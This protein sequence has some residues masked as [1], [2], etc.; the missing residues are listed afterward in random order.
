VK[1]LDFGVAT[2]MEDGP[3]SSKGRLVGTPVYMSPEQMRR[4][5]VDGRTDQFSWGVVAYELLSGATPWR[6]DGDAMTLASE[7][8]TRAAEPLRDRARDV[9]PNVADTV[10]RAL[11]KDRGERFASMRALTEALAP[12]V[13]LA[14]ETVEVPEPPPPPPRRPALFALAAAGAIALFVMAVAVRP[15]PATHEAVDAGCASNAACSRAHG[16]KAHRCDRATGA[17]VALESED[18][19]VLAAP[20]DVDSDETLWIGTMFPLTGPLAPKFGVGNAQAVDLARRDF[21]ETMGAFK[22]G[23]GAA[24]ARRIGLVSCDDAADPTRAARHLVEEVR[25]PAIIGFQTSAEL[26]ELAGSLFLPRG[27]LAMAAL[28]T[29]ALVTTLPQVRGE[30]RLV[31]RTTYNMTDTAAPLGLLVS[32]VLEPKIRAEPRGLG[33]TRPMRVALV[34]IDTAGWRAFSEG[35]LKALTFNGKSALDNGSDYREFVIDQDDSATAPD[36]IVASLLDFAPH[37]VLYAGGGSVTVRVIEPLEAR[38]PDKKQLRPRYATMNVSPSE[39][40]RF[41]SATDERRARF[42][43][44]TTVSTTPVNAQFV[45]HYNQ[46]FDDKITRAH[47][48]NSAYDAFY[49]V[50]YAAYALGPKPVD[51]KSLAT[52]MARFVPP[53][54]PIDIGP[55]SIFAAVEALQA[56]ENLDVT[57]ATGPLDFNPTTGEAPVDFVFLCVGRGEDGRTFEDVEAGLVYDAQTYRLEGALKCP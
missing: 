2:A 42:F 9:P 12:K 57:G 39:T 15:R 56:G 50:A 23:V 43:G 13:D 26:V 22:G 19:H 47:S 17:C 41:A 14:A 32:D 29:S 30:A 52:A 18:C 24:A 49:L 53:G 21:A 31:W 20:G 5:P 3:A 34:R 54:R 11:S 40:I 27:V 28:N 8:L 46:V 51:G 4:E 25:A 10:M 55:S 7:I 36:P 48:P 38:W 16:G 35:L 44:L 45:M 33:P 1:V 37:V 6:K